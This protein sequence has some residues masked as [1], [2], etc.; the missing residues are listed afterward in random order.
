MAIFRAFAFG[1]PP[2]SVMKTLQ[3]LRPPLLLTHA[4]NSQ[5][6]LGRLRIFCD[7]VPLALG[8]G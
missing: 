2:E 7:T 1:V 6:P 4:F 3:V 5:V 8:L